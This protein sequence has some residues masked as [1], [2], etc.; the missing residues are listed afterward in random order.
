MFNAGNIICILILKCQPD[1]NN[2]KEY[3]QDFLLI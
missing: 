1:R 2:P 3:S